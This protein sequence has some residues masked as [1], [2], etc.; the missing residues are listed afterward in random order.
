MW[1][2][3]VG[4]PAGYL[5]CNGQAISRSTYANLFSVIGTAYGAGDGSTTFNI[6]NA[7]MRL[8]HDSMPVV[9]NGK[10]LTMIDGSGGYFGIYGAKEA[11]RPQ[12]QAGTENCYVTLP[13]NGGG[14]L[15]SSKIL[16]VNTDPTK[17]SLI[18]AINYATAL[19][20]PQI[21]KY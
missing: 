12:L 13:A 15:T 18:G 2:S 4:I 14:K 9:G 16:G 10:S 20:F 11:S 6:P 7:S 19:V 3:N 21:I 8:L 5:L 17:P 1:H